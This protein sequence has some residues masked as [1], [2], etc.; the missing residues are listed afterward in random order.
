[1]SKQTVD[2]FFAKLT[3]EVITVESID[4]FMEEVGIDE[5]NAWLNRMGLP[6]PITEES[7]RRDLM[8]TIPKSKR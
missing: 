4:K 7:L 8:D 2:E 6:G 1:M 3:N 5:Y